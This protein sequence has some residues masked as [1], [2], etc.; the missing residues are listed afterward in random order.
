MSPQVPGSALCVKFTWPPYYILKATNARAEVSS[1]PWTPSPLNPTP[2]D[3]RRCQLSLPEALRTCIR[4]LVCVNACV[5]PAI[6]CGCVEKDAYH[7]IYHS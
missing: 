7:K 2:G 4:V 1:S 3:R 5:P 6:F